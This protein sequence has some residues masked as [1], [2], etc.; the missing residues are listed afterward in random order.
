MNNKSIFVF[1]ISA[2]LATGCGGG[3]SVSSN[4]SSSS[5]SSGSS[6][7]S[8]SST[9]TSSIT[10]NTA[11]T[12]KFSSTATSTDA[13]NLT[14]EIQTG[15]P[16]LITA[17]EVENM[18]A[19]PAGVDSLPA[20]TSVTKNCPAGGTMAIDSNISSGGTPTVGSYIDM[21]FSSCAILVNATTV[22][23]NG[24]GN[25]TYTAYANSFNY[26]MSISYTSLS[27]TVIDSASSLNTSYGPVSGSM[28]VEDIGGS[29]SYEI[30][31]ANGGATD[32]STASFIQ[33]NNM[34][35]ILNATYVYKST[36]AGGIIRVE[37][38][39]W[40][41]D[42][43]TGVPD[44]TGTITVTDASSNKL[45]ITENGTSVTAVYTVGG[46]SSAAYSVTFP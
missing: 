15:T 19:R 6:S 27:M 32:L 44:G 9:T 35:T 26:T 4:S 25:V 40:T 14:K 20:G 39:N 16:A 36:D 22:T 24:T 7:G 12:A 5:S 17:A 42:A 28:T 11:P 38:N 43:S 34:V 46:V 29:F 1:L 45:V 41:Y 10:T 8:S 33:S 21:T 13:S 31:L 30:Q 2:L 23:L 18:P 3:S 37:Y